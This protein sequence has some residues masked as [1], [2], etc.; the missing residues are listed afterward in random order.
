M[1]RNILNRQDFWLAVIAPNY[2]SEHDP[3]PPCRFRSGGKRTMWNCQ[4]VR[5]K[6]AVFLEPSIRSKGVSWVGW[7]PACPFDWFCG[8]LCNPSGSSLETSHSH[9]PRVSERR[10]QN[11]EKLRKKGSVV[12][13][14]TNTQTKTRKQSNNQT[15]K[16]ANK[17]TNE[18][19]NTNMQARQTL[20]PS[21]QTKTNK[22]NKTQTQN[23][24]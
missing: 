5:F 16:Q 10:N 9:T 24:H 18:Q 8:S 22:T 2:P 1:R 20:T 23:H 15:S 4:N 7:K 14:K 21:K 19:T 3:P 17:R 11:A 6:E 13:K 12:L